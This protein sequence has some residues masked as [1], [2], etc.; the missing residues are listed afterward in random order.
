MRGART[1]GGFFVSRN[2]VLHGVKSG[3]VAVLYAGE[4]LVEQHPTL[5]YTFANL[6]NARSRLPEVKVPSAVRDRADRNERP[7]GAK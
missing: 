4:Q 2:M 7:M 5:L 1:D 6:L 3:P